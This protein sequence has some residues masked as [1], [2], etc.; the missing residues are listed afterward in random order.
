MLDID[1]A[2]QLNAQ[3][4]ALK[5]ELDVYKAKIK[6]SGIGKFSGANYVAEVSERETSSL[7]TDRATIIA[8]RYKLDW[9]LK[10]VIDETKLEADLA[11]GTFND[12][13]VKEFANCVTTKKSLVLSF[14][15]K[16]KAKKL[17]VR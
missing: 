16:K 14:K 7:D 8:E 12:E 15:K 5:R 10:S 6:E 11:Q 4:T 13:I 1:A 9:L 17:V 2:A 3:I